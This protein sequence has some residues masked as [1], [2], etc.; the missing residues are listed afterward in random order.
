M[1]GFGGF[2]EPR[3]HGEAYLAEV[4]GDMAHALRRRGPDGQGVWVDARHG[5]AL[6]HA[7]LAILDRTDAGAQPMVSG[8]GR[9]VLAYNGEAY[10]TD[11]LHAELQRSGARFRGSSDTE[12]IVEGISRWG[13]PETLQRLIGMFALAAWDRREARLWLA[14]DR[15]GIKPLYWGRAGRSVVFGS[16]LGAL[17]AHPSFTGRVDRDVL[18]Q[19]FRHN[20]VPDPRCILEGVEKVAPGGLVVLDDPE[21]A[22]QSTWWSAQA[23]ALE[24]QGRSR[25]IGSAQ[26]A[27]DALDDALS[28]AVAVRLRADVPVGAFLSGG[29]DSSTVVAMMQ[30]RGGQKARTFSLGYDD[31]RYDESGH[32]AAVA[33]HLGTDH[34]QLTLDPEA[35]LGAIGELADVWDEPFADSSQIPTLILSRLTRDHVKVVLS[36]DGG[37]ELFGGYVRYRRMERLQRALGWVPRPCHGMLGLAV[38]SLGSASRRLHRR[39]GDRLQKLAEIFGSGDLRATYRALVSHWQAPASLV[40]GANEPAS[41]F[42]DGALDAAFPDAGERMAF[43]DTVTYLPGDILTKLDRATMSVGLEARVPLLD[44]RVF[45]LAWQIPRQWRVGRGGGK[46]VL[47]SVLG[48]Y[49]PDELFDRPKRGFAVPLERWLG[50]PWRDWAES[51]LDARRLR[52]EGLLDARIVRRHW[53]DHLAGRRR[54]HYLLWDVLM[55]QAWHERWR[56]RVASRRLVPA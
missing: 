31:P 29:V 46:A 1:C 54:W 36:G 24:A 8:C 12:V 26:E 27:A 53:E 51:L 50:G 19:F 15:L 17:A 34:T 18:T 40:P 47:R 39:T 20:Y 44:H 25:E 41:W 7:R 6:G 9:W 49:V 35:A 45:A 3:E 11:A 23:V 43:L 22:E 21:R 37:D 52:E 5:I 48:R 33:R 16:E 56:E 38:G 28:R 55:F 4:V 32:A 30:A 13:V 14:R 42:D 10:E 2:W